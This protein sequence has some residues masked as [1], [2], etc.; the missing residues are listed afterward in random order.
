[1]LKMFRDVGLSVLPIALIAFI[2]SIFTGVFSSSGISPSAFILSTILVIIG[3]AVFLLGVDVGLIP[4]GNQIGYK[5]TKKRNLTLILL[6][7]FAL[8]FFITMAEPD[9]QVFSSQVHDIDPT[10][11]KGLLVFMMAL[12][13]GS[14]V[15]FALLRTIYD[16]PFRRFMLLGVSLLF[17]LSAFVSEFFMTVSFDAGGSTTGP[18][19]VPFIMA[20][21]LGIAG[22]KE[23]GSENKFGFIGIASLGPVLFVLILGF[24]F[25]SSASIDSTGDM[26]TASQLFIYELKEVGF[27]LIPIVIMCVFMQFF[28][29]KLPKL[30]S[31]RIFIG[32][33]YTYFGLSLLLF[34]VKWGFM[35]VARELGAV[36]VSL[37]PIL[38]VALSFI[39]G[40]V[41]VLAEPAIHVLTEQV[42]EESDG[43][44]LGMVMLRYLSIGV[45]IAITAAS[46]RVLFNI[47]IWWF[48]FTGYFLIIVLMKWTPPL[49]IGIA[50]DSGGVACG[51]MTSTFLLPF[52]LGAAQAL[53]GENAAGV[54]FGVIALIAMVPI[55][56]VE[57]LGI[58]YGGADRKRK[59][60]IR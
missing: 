8:G 33:V 48:L 38:F 52:V 47:S 4:V 25:K 31:I 56:S 11:S 35:P 21:G 43:D 9:V 42:E 29:M 55:L 7:G 24:F 20:L 39:L 17:I 19:T 57:I 13:I 18:M 51:P 36:L 28:V 10:I 40:F 15:M 49:F 54:S 58:R 60:A 44:I 2:S 14:F 46:L 34:A 45:A 1:M 5:V 12:G 53:G 30:A 59:G 22:T 26:M 16:R 37:N 23:N 6:T 41:V 50:F 27:A 32:I 3:L